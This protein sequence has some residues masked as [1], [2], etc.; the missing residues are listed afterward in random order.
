M[1]TETCA[2]CGCS[3]Y[4]LHGQCSHVETKGI[5]MTVDK[6][7]A[8]I[9]VLKAQGAFLHFDQWLTDHVDLNERD[10]TRDRILALLADHPDLIEEGRSWGEMRELADRRLPD[11]ALGY[12]AAPARGSP[13]R[14]SEYTPPVFRN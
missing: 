8:G 7:V 2:E 14:S 12:P 9:E 3:L 10:R 13:C 5:A 11:T 4:W 6:W 1:D